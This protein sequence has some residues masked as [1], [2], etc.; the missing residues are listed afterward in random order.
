MTVEAL[1]V[2]MLDQGAS[3]NT[4]LMEW[5]KIWATNNKIIDHIA[6]WFN[7]I[8]DQTKSILTLTNA[9]ETVEGVSVDYH[10]KNKELGSRV[11]I[12]ANK[13]IVENQDMDGLQVGEKFTLRDLGN[14]FVTSIQ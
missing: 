9:Y 10:P 2:F 3:G 8:S 13:L 5:D 1:K 6:K 7:A 12:V 14:A 4:V 11:R